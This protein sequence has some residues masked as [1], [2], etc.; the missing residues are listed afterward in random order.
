MNNPFFFITS[1]DNISGTL[2][3]SILNE[4]PDINCSISYAD[5]FLTKLHISENHLADKIIDKFIEFNTHTNKK[6]HGN[7]QRFSAYELH[8]RILIEKT[9]SPIRKVNIAISPK[10]RIELLMKSWLDKFTHP[11]VAVTAIEKRFEELKKSKHSLFDQYIFHYFYGHIINT[12]VQK[13]IDLT[14]AKNKLFLLALAKTI[15]FDTADLPTP[16]KT[17]CFEDIIENEKNFI[18]FANYLTKNEVAISET[19]RYSVKLKLQSKTDFIYKLK[20]STWEDWQINFLDMYTQL[21]LHT[22]YYPHID[23]PLSV[24]YSDLGYQL[25]SKNKQDKPYSKLLSIQLNSNR[26]T[27]LI[28]YFDNIEET[29]DVPE[30]IEVLVNIDDTDKVMEEM[31]MK[32]TSQRKF[33]LKYVMTPRPKSF[34]DLWKPIN[35]LLEITDPDAYFL[36]NISDEMLFATKGWDTQLKKYVGFFP[37]HLFRLRA[38]RNKFRNY[39]DRWECSFGQDSIPITTKKWIDVGGDWNPCFGPDSYQQLIAFYL[40]K[41]GQFS[42]TNYLR[43]IPIIDIKFHGDVPSLGMDPKKVWKH[44]S[45]HLKAM[46]ICQ[47]YPMQLEARRR[48]ILIKAHIFAAANQIN[49]FEVVD[50]K[51]KKTIHLIRLDEQTT[52]VEMN[53]KLSWLTITLTNQWRKLQFNSYFGGGKETRKLIVLSFAG[54]LKAKYRFFEEIYQFLLRHR[55]SYLHTAK[56]ILRPHRLLK[57]IFLFKRKESKFIS[58]FNQLREL[59]KSICLENEHLQNKIYEQTSIPHV[60]YYPEKEKESTGT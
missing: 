37:D 50:N 31:L 30:D 14:D 57:K 27:Q 6:F 26:P 24:F 8:H 36:L 12:A 2:L 48:A 43:E 17:F 52:L 23:K 18:N 54:Y 25:Q 39:F 41:E 38:S 45:D 58:D 33:T 42:S 1:Y 7:A 56:L 59:Y 49:H 5:P 20:N 47:S 46:Q 13:K 3:A 4:H 9:K 10:L 32:E 29:A 34:C 22:I 40:A 55:Q 28:T 44:T 51:R 15:T 11:N 53:Y 16:I 35:K 21:R 19:Y 60:I